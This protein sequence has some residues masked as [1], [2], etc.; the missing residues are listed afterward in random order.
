MTAS[1]HTVEVL[2]VPLTVR[3]EGDE[4]EYIEELAAYVTA[5]GREIAGRARSISRERLALMVS[6]ALADELFR[7]GEALP[8]GRRTERRLKRLVER[9]EAVLQDVERG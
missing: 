5:R 9:I 6:L 1:R 2:G 3:L 7:K 8:G 4:P